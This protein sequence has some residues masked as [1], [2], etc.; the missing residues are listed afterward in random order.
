MPAERGADRRSV[1]QDRRVARARAQCLLGDPPRVA[2]TS[3]LEVHPGERVLGRDVSG[4]RGAP[5]GERQSFGDLPIV[6]RQ[7]P[8]QVVFLGGA[9]GTPQRL[10]TLIA[11]F[12]ILRVSEPLV[13]VADG[14]GEVGRFCSSGFL[15][16]HRERAVQVAFRLLQPGN[17]KPDEGMSGEHA[18]TPGKLPPRVRDAAGLQVELGELGVQPRR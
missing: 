15:A 18:L 1:V 11:A 7:E 6:I 5:L 17:G 2:Q 13:K 16:V 10:G 4:R 12:G 9:A 3:R 8:R 14:D